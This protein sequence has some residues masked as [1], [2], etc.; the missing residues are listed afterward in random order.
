[1]ILNSGYISAS[2]YDESTPTGQ[3]I[4]CKN[5]KINNEEL[6]EKNNFGGITAIIDIEKID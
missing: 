4:Y 6:S 1:M 2:S 5:L 3:Y